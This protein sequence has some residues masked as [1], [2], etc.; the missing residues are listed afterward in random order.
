MVSQSAKCRRRESYKPSYILALFGTMPPRNTNSSTC[1]TYSPS[2]TIRWSL[3]EILLHLAPCIVIPHFWH[4]F[5]SC[6][7]DRWSFSKIAD[8]GIVSSAYLMSIDKLSWSLSA[9]SR[10]FSSFMTNSWKILN[11][12]DKSR[13]PCLKPI[14]TANHSW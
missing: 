10:L 7:V 2:M 11:R 13:H 6:E 8:R 9:I 4:A 3:G 12:V 14:V 5:A 1:S